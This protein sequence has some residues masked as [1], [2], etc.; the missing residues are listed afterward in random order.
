MQQII[1]PLTLQMSTARTMSIISFQPVQTTPRADQRHSQNTRRPGDWANIIYTLTNT[2]IIIW[3]LYTRTM[4]PRNTCPVTYRP[5]TGM[6]LFTIKAYGSFTRKCIYYSQQYIAQLCSKYY[7]IK[8]QVVSVV[9]IRRLIGH[10]YCRTQ[11]LAFWRWTYNESL[12]CSFSSKL[13]S[14]SR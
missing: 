12:V 2:Y 11:N 8:G 10:S 3:L 1:C 13:Q 6:A 4:D 9:D 14:S 5:S 7:S